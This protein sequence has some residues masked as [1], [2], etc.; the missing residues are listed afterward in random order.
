MSDDNKTRFE[1]LGEETNSKPAATKAPLKYFVVYNGK[2]KLKASGVADGEFVKPGEEYEVT[3]NVHDS[4]I[5][6]D[7]WKTFTK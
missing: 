6:A 1:K 4:F 3:K 2:A 5:R 7:G